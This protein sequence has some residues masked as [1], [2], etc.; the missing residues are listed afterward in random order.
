MTPALRAPGDG[1]VARVGV[2][3]C[4]ALLTALQRKRKIQVS[5][6]TLGRLEASPPACRQA[7]RPRCLPWEQAAAAGGALVG[8]GHRGPGGEQEP[9][10]VPAITRAVFC[11]RKPHVSQPREESKARHRHSPTEETSATAS[12]SRRPGVSI[13]GSC[14]IPPARGAPGQRGHPCPHTTAA[15]RRP[16]PSRSSGSGPTAPPARSH[17]APLLPPKLAAKRKAARLAPR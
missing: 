16:G 11:G 9:S 6:A 5:L 7:P 17:R 4:P 10:Q 12:P 3:G 1:L 13:G 14:G 15:R 8:M 2:W